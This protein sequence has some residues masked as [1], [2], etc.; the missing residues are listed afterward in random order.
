MQLQR[1]PALRYLDGLRALGPAVGLYLIAVA[2]VGFVVDGGVFAVLLNLYLLR[3]GYGPA[4]IGLVNAAGTLAF[5]V[6]SLPAGA[7]G[8][9]IGTLRALIIGM[10]LMLVSSTLLPLA[11]VLP[12]EVR[13]PWLMVTL[14]VSYIGLALFFVNTAPFLLG[15][16]AAD[17]RT[18][19]FGLQTAL[20][21]LAAFLGSLVGGLLPPL[22]AGLLGVD[23]N[24]AAPF[25]YAL[26]L[27]GLALL[28]AIAAARAITP[29]ATAPPAERPAAAMG[30]PVVAGSILGLLLL[31]TLVRLLQVAGLAATTTYF[32]VYL[33][34]ELL[35]P[36]AQIGAIIAA[37]RLL[38]VPAAL[39][40]P[41]L[42]GRFGKPAV[43][44]GATLA[45]AL[46]I[47]PLALIPRWEAAA[48][49]FVGLVGLSW[50]RY[51]ATIVY[52]LELVP[53]T[54][55]ATASGLSEM[56]SGICF[57]LITF[58]GGYMILLLG[59]RSLFLTAAAVT[60]L[61]ALVFWLAF[62]GRTPYAET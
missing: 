23:A 10:V 41:W 42:T 22:L 51:S 2:L 11:D 36:T 58:G 47:L 27:S 57:T 32:N 6:A 34:A 48:I 37:G 12:P 17:Q 25:R 61:S 5:A 26:M 21:S 54:R 62:R 55:R 52:I 16:V 31:I 46:A 56:A 29:Q 33:D 30:A 50:I 19:V 3:V 35:L 60:A 24:A 53:P 8:E 44:I 18:K 40:V 13:L 43:A 4:E 39:A 45:S 14:S 20:L 28:G 7:L 9:R 1:S 59:Y 38:G 49:S 15:A